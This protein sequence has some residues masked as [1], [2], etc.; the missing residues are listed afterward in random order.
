MRLRTRGHQPIALDAP[1]HEEARAPAIVL[2]RL[3][4][5]E[6]ARRGREH[7]GEL[8]RG[9]G[10][11]TRERAV[12]RTVARRCF[13]ARRDGEREGAEDAVRG[14]LELELALLGHRCFH[15]IGL[16]YTCIA[17]SP[18][19]RSAKMSMVKVSSS[20]WQNGGDPSC[21]VELSVLSSATI[22][23]G[24]FSMCR[25]RSVTWSIG[26]KPTIT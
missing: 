4:E 9:V 8:R 20:F 10:E 23:P 18:A 13:R 25:S 11:R 26:E 3:L 19:P 2:A 5:G 16:K 14:R 24:A 1:A 12:E 6:R 21:G 17:T 15:V 22:K 7:D